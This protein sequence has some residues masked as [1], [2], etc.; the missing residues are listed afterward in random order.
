MQNDDR[1]NNLIKLQEKDSTGKHFDPSYLQAKKHIDDR[2]LNHHVWETLHQELRRSVDKKPLKILEIGAGIGTMFA[3]LVERKLLTGT[4][5]YLATDMDLAQLR[6]ARQYLSQWAEEHSYQWS[7]G[8][9]G[10]QLSTAEAEI[11]LT[12]D[13]LRAEELAI[14]RNS[15][16]QFDLI[17]AHAVL[18]LVDL[19]AVLPPLLSRLTPNG[20]AYFSCNFDGETVF[21]PECAGEEDII[22]RYHGSMETRSAGASHT[23][24]RLLTLLQQT[25]AAILA[26]G[27]SDWVIHPRETKYSQDEIFFLHAIIETIKNELSGDDQSSFHRA[28][29]LT[30]TRLRRQQAEDG[31]LSFL[32]RH[33]DLLAQ[34]H[35]VS[36]QI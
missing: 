2:A 28:K 7:W 3:R 29:L 20:L 22:R 9:N 26:A 33:L 4:L 23:G 14:E 32:A 17:I 36:S 15:L 21:L 27:S 6:V 31:Q 30:W 35:T 18:D 19:Y 8:E 25:D 1:L 34:N 13:Q 10:G 16:G 5:N 12:F 24:R 11:T